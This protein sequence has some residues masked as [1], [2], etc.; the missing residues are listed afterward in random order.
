MAMELGANTWILIGI[1]LLEILFIII[2]ALIA[3][4]V[5]NTSIKDEIIFMGFHKNIDS[6]Q[7][8]IIKVLVGI[9]LGFTFFFISGYIIYLFKNII[10]KSLFG[11]GFVK[12][13]EQGGIN[14]V[15]LEP[16]LFQLIIII[17]LHI[18]LVGICEEA[19]FRGFIIKKCEMKLNQVF[20]ILFSSV[21]FAFY[22]TPPFLVPIT[23]IITYFGYYFTFGVL[24][25]VLFK[26]FHNSLIPCAIAHGILNTLIL[27]F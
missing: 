6:I 10:V 26:I 3:S 8:N 27:I 7:K 19:F 9:G 4:K 12:K 21:C 17:I 2:P 5:E 11:S 22:H 13:G 14:T 24:L 25:S 16:N 23:T 18:L 1:M 20:A 15:P